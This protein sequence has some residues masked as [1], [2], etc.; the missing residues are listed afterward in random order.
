MNNIL[1]PGSNTPSTGS[2][3][4]RSASWMSSTG[5]WLRARILP[6]TITPSP[7]WRCGYSKNVMRR[8]RRSWTWTFDLPPD[9]LWPV[10]PGRLHRNPH[11]NRFNEAM[12]LPPYV[13]EETPQPNGT[14]L[15]RGQQVQWAARP[16][17]SPSN[18]R[19][20]PTGGSKGPPFPP[21]PRVHQGPVPR[22]RPGVRSR[23]RRRITG[24]DRYDLRARKRRL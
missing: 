5:G 22:L 18:G 7:I 6:A 11:T 24:V 2:R 12:G 8:T 10:L 21:G 3:W 4:K 13:L 17:A 14:I 19:R 15:R 1:P 16:R 20:S 9:Q 23:A